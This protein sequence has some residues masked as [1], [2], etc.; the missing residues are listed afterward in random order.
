MSR[1]RK[2]KYFSV[3]K[4]YPSNDSPI[5][6]LHG[7]PNSNLDT[8]RKK[9]GTFYRR[10]KFG[11][12]GDAYLDLDTPHEHDSIDHAHDIYNGHRETRRELSKREKSEINKAKRK[13]RL[14][15]G[16]K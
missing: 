14:W 1:K 7:E 4:N 2:Y 16:K 3:G 10:R 13:R 5:T 9:D 12:S 15:N 11:S 8:Y 6:P